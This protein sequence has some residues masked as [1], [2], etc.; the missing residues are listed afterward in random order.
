MDTSIKKIIPLKRY[1][2]VAILQRSFRNIDVSISIFLLARLGFAQCSGSWKTRLRMDW[3][4]EGIKD[5]LMKQIDG[6]VRDV[7]HISVRA[8]ASKCVMKNDHETLKTGF[9]KGSGQWCKY[10]GG[11]SRHN[12]TIISKLQHCRLLQLSF[13]EATELSFKR[14][15]LTHASLFE[16]F[17]GHVPNTRRKWSCGSVKHR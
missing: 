14:T 1:K 4:L 7:T 9:G 16:K 2:N 11:A 5:K 15:G 17:Q 3:K 10:S 6:S 8:R 13:L 12:L